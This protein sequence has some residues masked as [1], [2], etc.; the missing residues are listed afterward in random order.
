MVYLFI[1][2]DSLSKDTRLKRLRQELFSPQIEQFN[3]DILYAKEL[4]LKGLQEKFLCL[5]IKA[6]KRLIVI[7]DAEAL[8]EEIK[9]FLLKEIKHFSSHIT[10]VLDIR[11]TEDRDEFIKR[12]S[13]QA[14]VYRF[15]ETIPPDTFTLARGIELKK[16]DYALRLLQQLLQNRQRPEW[17]LGGLRYSWERSVTHPLEKRKR[18][19]L[20]L[21]CDREIKT[22]R[23]KPSFALEKLVINLCCL[24]KPFS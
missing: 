13:S 19:R 7:K 4:S 12:I 5:P 16:P 2:Q 1:G 24:G 17:I 18:L 21:N 6:K 20:L 23:V 10:L 9:E 3:L 14:Q 11:R 22:G 8:K 15:K